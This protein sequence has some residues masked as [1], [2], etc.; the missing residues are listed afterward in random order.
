MSM[1]NGRAT[2]IIRAHNMR[3]HWVEGMLKHEIGECAFCA[4]PVLGEGCIQLEKM[5]QSVQSSLS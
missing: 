2:V 5:P 1:V 3:E 4:G